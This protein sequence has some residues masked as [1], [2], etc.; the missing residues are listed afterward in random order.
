MKDSKYYIIKAVIVAG[1]IVIALVFMI[2][3]TGEGCMVKWLTGISCPTCGTT[4]SLYSLANLDFKGYV[5]YHAL[6]VPMCLYFFYI[7]VFEPPF[8]KKK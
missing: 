8:T 5:H 2:M 1:I 7:L 3:I 4:R 6:G